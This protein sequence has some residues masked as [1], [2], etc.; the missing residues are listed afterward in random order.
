[1]WFLKSLPQPEAMLPS[2]T[3]THIDFEIDHIKMSG[4]STF[5]RAYMSLK[6]FQVCRS[7]HVA[8]YLKFFWL[9]LPWMFYLTTDN[10]LMLFQHHSYSEARPGAAWTLH[11]VCKNK[12][13]RNYWPRFSQN[14]WGEL[15]P[16]TFLLRL[17]CSPL[18]TPFNS[19]FQHT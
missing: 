16:S 17:S 14:F 6:W 12:T 15:S 13:L 11:P 9:Q 7:F 19:R 5:Q 3:L 4:A 2:N 18:L 8:E 1:M 10:A